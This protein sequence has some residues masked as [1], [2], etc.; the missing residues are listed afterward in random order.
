MHAGANVL[1]SVALCLTA[2]AIG[3]WLAALFGRA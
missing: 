1:L 2:V 3:H